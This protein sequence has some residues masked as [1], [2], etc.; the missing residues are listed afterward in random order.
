MGQKI[1]P[2]NHRLGIIE[3][4]QSKWFAPRNKFRANLKQDIQIRSFLRKKLKDARVEMVG[5]ERSGKGD[6]VIVNIHTA[7]PGMVIGRGGEGAETLKKE[8]E[9]VVLQG[10]G[11]VKINIHEIRQSNL[12]AAVVAQ[13]IA[14][15]LE[16]RI[17]FRRASKQAL[18]NVKKAGALG[19]KV[20]VKGRLNGAEIARS[21]TISWGSIPLH[22]L[23]ANIDYSQETAHTTYGAIGVTVWIYKGE[24]LDPE[25]KS[26]AR[27]GT[28]TIL[29]QI[30]KITD[31]RAES[32]PEPEPESEP[33]E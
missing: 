1:H 26:D 19:V 5:L 32:E 17:P 11:K 13:N 9:A 33:L 29:K 22:T 20:R 12:S 28:D 30:K 10:I 24:V 14:A 6:E 2:K 7:K 18:E 21:E 31:K 23:R 25:D 8:V 27:G 15:D 16:R 3:D 4:W